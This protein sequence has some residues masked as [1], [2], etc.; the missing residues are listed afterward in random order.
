MSAVSEETISNIKTVKCFAEEK[1]HIGQFD[2]ANYEVFEH[3]R[4]KAYF[5][6]VFFFSQKLFGNGSDVLILFLISLLFV[7]LEMTPGQATSIMLYIT[8][9]NQAF[10]EVSM[11]L[12]QL[13]KVYGSSYECAKLIV[14]P[15]ALDWS[16]KKKD[17]DNTSK[18]NLR[19]ENVRF[20]YPTRPETPILNGVTIDVKTNSVVALVGASGC[21]KSSIIQLMERFYDPDQGTMWFNDDDLKELDNAWYHQT[22][23]ALVQQEPILFS[24]SVKDNILYGCR[25]FDHLTE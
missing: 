7:K 2:K 3:G 15:P 16:G 18:G 8:T 10:N 1:T 12:V 5:F 17:L 19:V 22:Q 4:A 21:G 25:Q 23:V 6:A 9:I 14:E 13:S 20:A 11:N 24:G